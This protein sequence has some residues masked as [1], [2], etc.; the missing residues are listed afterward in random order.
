[1]AMPSTII[2]SQ[3][4]SSSTS[5]QSVKGGSNP[6]ASVVTIVLLA[7][8]LKHSIKLPTDYNSYLIW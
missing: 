1:M 5:M 7:L 8:T 4:L 2:S 3:K 6:T